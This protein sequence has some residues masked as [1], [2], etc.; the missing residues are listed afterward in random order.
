MI[1]KQQ[2]GREMVD[3]KYV[4]DNFQ[5]TGHHGGTEA[6]QSMWETWVQR[7]KAGLHPIVFKK[8]MDKRGNLCDAKYTIDDTPLPGEKRFGRGDNLRM[9]VNVD[10]K[11]DLEHRMGSDEEVDKYY[12]AV[13]PLGLS[14]L[15][16]SGIK[17]G[18][19]NPVDKLLSF[20][21]QESIG[22][23]SG[24]LGGATEEENGNKPENHER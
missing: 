8:W 15:K 17:E 2:C 11:S 20:M 12:N 6:L 7:Q 18:T 24:A 13:D 22:S 4:P 3:S 1:Q 9:D 14:A 16:G 21:N 23:T 5:W 19:P 10:E